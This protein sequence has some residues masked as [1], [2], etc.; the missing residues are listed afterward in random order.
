MLKLAGI[1]KDAQILG[2]WGNEI[3]RVLQAESAGD[4]AL[5]VYIETPQRTIVVPF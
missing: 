1:K 2:I 5:T 4:N 3:V